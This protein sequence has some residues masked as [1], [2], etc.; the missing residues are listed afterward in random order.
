MYLIESY[1]KIQTTNNSNSDVFFEAISHGDIFQVRKYLTMGLSPNTKTS[2]GFPALHRAVLENNLEI[3][4]ML[5][6]HGAKVDAGSSGGLTALMVASYFNLDEMVAW[7]L[8][9]GAN[10]FLYSDNG[11]CALDIAAEKGNLRSIGILIEA[12]PR[13]NPSQTVKRLRK[14]LFIAEKNKHIKTV[15]MV[16][17]ALTAFTN[18]VKCHIFKERNIPCY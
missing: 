17:A 16:E 2:D 10:Q 13:D 11:Y 8:L 15:K 14:A 3:A 6:N 9:F 12:L 4:Y 7:L 18:T 5:L 1:T